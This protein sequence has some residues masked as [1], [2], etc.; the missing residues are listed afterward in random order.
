MYAVFYMERFCGHGCCTLVE[1]LGSARAQQYD[2]AQ[3][4][5]YAS[6]SFLLQEL[7]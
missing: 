2:Y 3:L 1:V 7:Q 5:H 6:A 4:Q